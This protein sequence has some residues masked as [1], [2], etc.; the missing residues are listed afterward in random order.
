MSAPPPI[1]VEAVA[2][3]VSPEFPKD[4]DTVTVTF[5]I[6]NTGAGTVAK[7]PWAIHNATGNQQLASGSLQNLTPGQSVQLPPATWTAKPGNQ[8]LQ[9]YVDPTGK[10]LANTAPV[11][12]QILE[13]NLYVPKQGERVLSVTFGGTGVGYVESTEGQH[14][15]TSSSTSGARGTTVSGPTISCGVQGFDGSR[16]N[17]QGNGRRCQ[18]TIRGHVKLEAHAKAGFTFTGW[19]GAC[20]S[21]G[22]AATC[23]VTVNTTTGVAATFQSQSQPQ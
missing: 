9:G 2:L 11:A 19:G 3:S 12:R 13:R 18:A 1:K 5:T 17:D 7:V 23:D 4:G 6:K 8:M 10:E 14:S 15:Q 20:A 21:A 22:T 16:T